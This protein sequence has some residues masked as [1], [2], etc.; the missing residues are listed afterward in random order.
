MQPLAPGLTPRFSCTSYTCDS[1]PCATSGRMIGSHHQPSTAREAAPEDCT[2]RRVSRA[3]NSLLGTEPDD[4]QKPVNH[5]MTNFS[6]RQQNICVQRNCLQNLTLAH[7]RNS[8]F[9][10]LLS[11]PRFRKEQWPMN[12]SMSERTI[13]LPVWGRECGKNA[14]RIEGGHNPA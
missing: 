14:A 8:L 4:I 1:R 13:T 3:A 7:F 2:A 6:Q 5:E 9:Y 10:V 11:R 12:N